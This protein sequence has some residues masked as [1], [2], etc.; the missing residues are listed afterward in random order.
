[1]IAAVFSP[2]YVG[3]LLLTAL[4]LWFILGA[5]GKWWVKASLILAVPAFMVVVWFSLSSFNGWPTTAKTPKTALYVYGYTIEPDTNVGLKGAI[6][7]WLIPSQAQNGVLDYHS[8][9]GEP[10]AY[11]L[12]YSKQLE[13]EVQTANKAVANGERIEFRTGSKKGGKGVANKPGKGKPASGI[14]GS[15]RSGGTFHFYNL[16]PPVLSPKGA[17]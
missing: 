17:Q 1:M 12:P 15:R 7:V 6:Y 3:F 10:R 9:I 14:G 5:R 4:L 16:R 13:G 11:V 2:I 8:K